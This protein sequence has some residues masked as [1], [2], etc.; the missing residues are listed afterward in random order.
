MV[1]MLV[2]TTVAL[3]AERMGELTGVCLVLRTV[4]MLV[5][6]AVVPM[7][8][9]KGRWLVVYSADWLGSSLGEHW[10]EKWDV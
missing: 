1:A 8:D 3:K 4:V 9:W 10:V 7:V 6:R 2:S 5:D